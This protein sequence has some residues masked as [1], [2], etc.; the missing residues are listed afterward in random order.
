MAIKT[1]MIVIL[2]TIYLNILHRNKAVEFV[3]CESEAGTKQ[4]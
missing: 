4:V 3:D 1:V 2:M